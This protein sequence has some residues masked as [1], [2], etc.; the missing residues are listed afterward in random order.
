MP[1]SRRR[2]LLS[3]AA[4]GTAPL[5]RRAEAH[6]AAATGHAEGAGDADT[7]APNAQAENPYSYRR[8][9]GRWGA[10]DQMGAVNLI[11]PAKR[12]AASALV[13]TGR[14]VSLSRVFQPEQQFIRI[15]QRT[16]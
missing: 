15:N 1:S 3:A 4:F 6:P 8:N 10:Y 13:K 14:A 11:T 9:W 2:F 16:A 5:I 12:A 7:L